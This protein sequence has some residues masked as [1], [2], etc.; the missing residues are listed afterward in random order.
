MLHIVELAQTRFSLIVFLSIFLLIDFL[1]VLSLGESGLRV[2]TPLE[3]IIFLCP[4]RTQPK[5]INIAKNL[6]KLGTPVLHLKVE[7]LSSPGE[8]VCWLREE[9]Q[10]SWSFQFGSPNLDFWLPRFRKS[11]NS[12]IHIHCVF[13]LSCIW[14]CTYINMT[15]TNYKY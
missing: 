3:W 2:A 4:P 1:M 6:W 13:S 15:T 14:I 11:S 7:C 10:C 12:K 9:P 8:R 5:L